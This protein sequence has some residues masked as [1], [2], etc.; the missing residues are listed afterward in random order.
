MRYA[1]SFPGARTGS[2]AALAAHFACD[3]RAQLRLYEHHKR[4]QHAKHQKAARRCNEQ[5]HGLERGA[6]HG[7][8]EQRARAQKLAHAAHQH[9]RQG[10]AKAHAKAVQ[11]GIQHG[12]LRSEHFGAAEDDAVH[13][14]K[15]QVDAK[16]RVQR[17]QVRLHQHL[18]HCDKCGNH[19]DKG[20]QAHLVG[21]HLAQRRNNNI[22]TDEHKCGGKAHAKAVH[23][24]SS[25]G[26][27]GAG[28]Q[29]QA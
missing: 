2:R 21:Y 16:R 3:A 4:H 20:R 22:G 17:G 9:Q 10:K 23:G 6:Q 7:H 13:H 25:D 11:R 18:Q 14:N 29:H 5:R 12:V 1:P 26:Q 8:A 27:C 19:R 15:R 28:A 24:H